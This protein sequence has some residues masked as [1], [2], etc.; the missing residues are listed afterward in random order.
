MRLLL[1]NS[2]AENNSLILPTEYL[3]LSLSNPSSSLLSNNLAPFLRDDI[4][5]E[6]YKNSNS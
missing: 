4:K 3:L 6:N 2:D 5:V 1:L